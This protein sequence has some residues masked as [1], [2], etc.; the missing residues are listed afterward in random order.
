MFIE[1][2]YP[3]LYPHNLQLYPHMFC[4]IILYILG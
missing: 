4:Y 1:P 2:I 3:Y